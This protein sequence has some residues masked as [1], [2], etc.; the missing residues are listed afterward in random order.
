LGLNLETMFAGLIILAFV[1][2]LALRSVL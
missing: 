1:Q 2:E